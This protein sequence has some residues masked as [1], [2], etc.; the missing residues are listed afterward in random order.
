MM[1]PLIPYYSQGNGHLETYEG[2]S[3]RQLG[4]DNVISDIIRIYTHRT[5]SERKE[6]T[7]QLHHTALG[8][9][10]CLPF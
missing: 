6:R 5:L 3:L 1:I 10:L 8:I 7:L 4:E 9:N 2:L